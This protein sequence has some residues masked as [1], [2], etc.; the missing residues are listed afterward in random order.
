LLKA[1]GDPLKNQA[2]ADYKQDTTLMLLG[3]KMY[4]VA[5]GNLIVELHSVVF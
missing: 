5:G 1:L 4:L 3:V 2:G